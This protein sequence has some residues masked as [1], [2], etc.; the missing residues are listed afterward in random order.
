MMLLQVMLWLQVMMLLQVILW[1]QVQIQE[2]VLNGLCKHILCLIL[3]LILRFLLEVYH[4]I[5]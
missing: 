2:Q 1:L 4:H 5:F 3:I